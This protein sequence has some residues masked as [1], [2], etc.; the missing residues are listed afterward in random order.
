M[1]ILKLEELTKKYPK[2]HHVQLD[3]NAIYDFGQVNLNSA[4]L[5]GSFW[6]V[7]LTL[8]LIAFFTNQ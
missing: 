4:I 6:L 7:F 8:F 5:I 3:Q 1:W 2:C